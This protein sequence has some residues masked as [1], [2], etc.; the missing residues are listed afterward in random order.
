MSR[1]ASLGLVVSTA[2]ADRRARSA[3]GM[4]PMAKPHLQN[5]AEEGQVVLHFG[6]ATWKGVLQSGQMGVP[7]LHRAPQAP[8]VCN[9]LAVGAEGTSRL[10]LRREHT[11][12]IAAVTS[13]VDRPCFLPRLMSVSTT[14]AWTLPSPAPACSA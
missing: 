3:K 13:S 9:W 5:R 14:W 12:W 6:Q 1:S 11:S 7:V 10:H 4:S 8:Q 2:R